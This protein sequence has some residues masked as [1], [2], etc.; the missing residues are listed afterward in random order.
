MIQSLMGS[1]DC[2]ST[3]DLEASYAKIK[4]ALKRDTENT[5]A[6]VAELEKKS[7]TLD[8]Q[9]SA[10]R[11]QNE[12]TITVIVSYPLHYALIFYNSCHRTS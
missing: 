8:A 11:V 3:S 5:S 7:L 6:H 9:F 10:L 2:R 4:S 1:V 12:V